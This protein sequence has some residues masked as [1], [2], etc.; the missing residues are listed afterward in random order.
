[1]A[2]AYTTATAHPTALSVIIET[3]CIAHEFI[4]TTNMNIVNPLR[5][6]VDVLLRQLCYDRFIWYL[7]IVIGIDTITLLGYKCWP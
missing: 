1:M 6:N 7:D 2:A 3:A 5:A 4:S